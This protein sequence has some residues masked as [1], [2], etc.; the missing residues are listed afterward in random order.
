MD[1]AEVIAGMIMSMMLILPMASSQVSLTEGEPD[2]IHLYD[3]ISIFRACSYYSLDD[4]SELKA[5]T[6]GTLT[7]DSKTELYGVIKG[8]SWEWKHVESYMGTEEKVNY[9]NVTVCDNTTK[10]EKCWLEER[11]NTTSVPKLMQ[12][13]LWKGYEGFKELY[14][15]LPSVKEKPSQIVRYCADI[16]REWTDEG[17]TIKTD[18]IPQFDGKVYK[19]YNW[20]NN[21]IAYKRSLTQDDSL[22]PMFI[23]GSQKLTINGTDEWIWCQNGSAYLYYNNDTNN[24]V[25]CVNS[26][27]DALMGT[28]VHLDDFPDSGGSWKAYSSHAFH[29]NGTDV[30]NEIGTSGSTNCG[31]QA[32]VIGNGLDCSTNLNI[33]H[34]SMMDT[35]PSS[36]CLSM[37]VNPDVAIDS[38]SVRMQIF[39][40]YENG[41]AQ[42]YAW[43]MRSSDSNPGGVQYGINNGAAGKVVYGSQGSYASGTSYH[44]LFCFGK[45]GMNFYLNGAED[46]GDDSF[47]SNP[48]GGTTNSF[49]VNTNFG[50]GY[51]SNCD[52]DEIMFFNGSFTDAMANATYWSQVLSYS[53]SVLGA[54]ETDS[55]GASEEF[56]NTTLESP[57]NATVTSDSTPD[58]TFRFNGTFATAS[59]ELLIDGV[60][61]G[62][63]SSTVNSTST[64]LTANATLTDNIHHWVV[65][66]TNS[67]YESESDQNWTI[68]VDTTMPA[69]K[70]ISGTDTAG[71][72][73]KDYIFI[74]I[75]ASDTNLDNVSFSW[76]G[77]NRSDWNDT[78]GLHYW[79]NFTSL[80]DGNYTFYAWAN[81]TVAYQNNT[82]SR[83]IGIDS[84][85][86]DISWLTPTPNN[87]SYSWDG[88]YVNVSVSE[89]ASCSAEI[90]GTN[91]TL[92]DQ[93]ANVYQRLYVAADE[94]YYVFMVY[95]NDPAG[96]LNKTGMRWVTLDWPFQHGAGPGPSSGDIDPDSPEPGQVPEPYDHDFDWEVWEVVGLMIAIC[97]AGGILMLR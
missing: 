74:N 24:D 86:P 76:N 22:A 30:H 27:E 4:F 39:E 60:G 89:A 62:V 54:Q 15:S 97:L 63:N 87:S 88:F 19:E 72:Q 83:E 51:D 1:K 36:G 14:D 45:N 34:A 10:E 93:G 91:L 56:Y 28:D 90:N 94:E 58:F 53:Y 5:L 82:P 21:S 75:S 85:V 64:T 3:D 49:F 95:C 16:E 13:T 81:D 47:T 12:R 65:N 71:W 43:F 42:M 46:A 84:S 73:T 38:P 32:V 50:A 79:V 80:P 2:L 17:F 96:N 68:T 8:G 69:V 9:Y 41:S 29:L 23:A 26:A 55:G 52:Y 7:L 31:S 70:Y 20:W 6:S 66:C 18:I 11:Q 67:T 61:F 92:A 48:G 59:C 57:S 25:Y 40:K 35:Y 37:W 77:T 33:Q 44:F 78:D